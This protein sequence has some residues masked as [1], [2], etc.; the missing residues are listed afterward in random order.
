MSGRPAQ[1]PA[2][3]RSGTEE[4]QH[5]RDYKCQTD[6]N[7]GQTKNLDV[8]FPEKDAYGIETKQQYQNQ[9]ADSEAIGNKEMGPFQT[10]CTSYIRNIIT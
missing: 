7:K 5:H 9:T 3:L 2:K 6:S 10:S 4:R 8:R 1:S